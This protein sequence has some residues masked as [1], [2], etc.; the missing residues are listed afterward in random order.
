[1]PYAFDACAS[2]QSHDDATHDQR[3]VLCNALNDEHD[4]PRGVLSCDAHDAYAHGDAHDHVDELVL[5]D[6]IS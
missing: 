2:A 1:M 3:R 4:H 6:V 5:R